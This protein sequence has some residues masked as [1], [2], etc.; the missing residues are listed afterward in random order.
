MT[1]RNQE[2]LGFYT[3][4]TNNS[5]NLAY[6]NPYKFLRSYS[7]QKYLRFLLHANKYKW[8]IRKGS[9][10]IKEMNGNQHQSCSDASHE[11]FSPQ[12]L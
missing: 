5:S 9:F 11:Y 2:N 10:F 4:M 7:R 6:L 3:K 12:Q 8:C 1:A